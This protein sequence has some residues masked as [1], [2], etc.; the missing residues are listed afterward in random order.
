MGLVFGARALVEHHP[1]QEHGVRRGGHQVI[2]ARAKGGQGR[3]Q[4]VCQ[5][6]RRRS[7]S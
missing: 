1:G 6:D 2:G 4:R 5:G 7:R 3:L